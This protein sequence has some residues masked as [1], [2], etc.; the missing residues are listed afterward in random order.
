MSGP[1]NARPRPAGARTTSGASAARS[2]SASRDDDEHDRAHHHDGL[3]A[4]RSCLLIDEDRQRAR[5]MQRQSR[6]VS[7]V[8]RV[9]HRIHRGAAQAPPALRERRETYLGGVRLIVHG[10]GTVADGDDQGRPQ[11]VILDGLDRGQ[12]PAVRRPPLSAATST[13]VVP[14][15]EERAR[16]TWPL[17]RWARP[18]GRNDAVSLRTTLAID[19]K[20]KT[21]AIVTPIQKQTTGQRYRTAARASPRAQ[22]NPR[23]RVTEWRRGWEAIYRPKERN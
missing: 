7:R 9:P 21:D 12:I 19:G 20:K 4:N 1:A 6:I 11:G 14:L 8:K 16:P 5:D 10:H 22:P 18:A 17:R 2:A 13:P 23:F 3:S 15:G